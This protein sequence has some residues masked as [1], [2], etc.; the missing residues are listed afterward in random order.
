MDLGAQTGVAGGRQDVEDGAGAVPSPHGECETLAKL[1]LPEPLVH[2]LHQR[3]I[4]I[5]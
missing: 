5:Y 4:S 1:L 3:G 2:G